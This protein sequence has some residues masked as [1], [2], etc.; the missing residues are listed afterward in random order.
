VQDWNIFGN[1]GVGVRAE[2][3]S[4]LDRMLFIEQPDLKSF[5]NVRRGPTDFQQHAIRVRCG[6]LEPVGFSERDG[7]PVIVR[8]RSKI[9]GELGWS[10]VVAVI[11]AGWIRN[12][13]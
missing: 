2:E 9:L 10:Q 6:D 13:A 5:I 12:L 7:S 4:M 8:G 1:G 3:F 11:C